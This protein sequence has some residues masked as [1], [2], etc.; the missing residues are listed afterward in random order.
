MK[1]LAFHKA[2]APSGATRLRPSVRY[3]R[4]LAMMLL[5]AL[6]LIASTQNVSWAQERAET[7]SEAAPSICNVFWQPDQL[8]QGSP[9]LF[10]VE[11][12][13]AATHVS[14]TWTGHR[15]KF[16]PAEKPRI[17]Y[18]LAG[19]DIDLQPGNHDLIVTAVLRSGH[20]AR[21]TKSV[22][23][24]AAN[25]GSGSA[26]VAEQYVQP[27]P[28]EQRQIAA[29]ELLKKRAYAHVTPRPL[30]SGDFIK[31]VQ[32]ESTPSFG[33][34]RLLNE[35]RTSRHLGTD[36]PVKEGSTVRV[37]NAG[38]VVLARKL[39]YEGNCVIVDHG[40]SFFTVYMHLDKIDVHLGERLRKGAVLGVSGDTGRVTG[41]HFHMGVR[42]S[43]AWLDP[44]ALLG[45]TLP[46]RR[47]T[48][49]R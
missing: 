5:A 48:P 14:A 29:D 3:V 28:A 27:N 1:A 16:F 32:A 35:E 23:V 47:A 12:S 11:L 4:S 39:F 25:F 9:I 19:A 45:M 38:T 34:T 26:N 15:L 7:E 8:Q 24:N 21:T 41:P 44:V 13:G 46:D 40:E 37:S 36:F 18:A 10:Q 49:A 43:G 17:W 20:V 2:S 33:E 42:W 6:T 22:E 31:P 30:W